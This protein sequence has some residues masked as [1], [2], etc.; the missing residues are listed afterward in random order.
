[1]QLQERV[2]ERLYWLVEKLI[3]LQARGV[4]NL[5]IGLLRQIKG[6]YQE[7]LILFILQAV[8]IAHKI[9]LG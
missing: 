6:M 2:R 1:M 5:V 4:E 8:R 7:F 9:I 3:A